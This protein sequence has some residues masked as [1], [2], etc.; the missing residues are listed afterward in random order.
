MSPVLPSLRIFYRD[1]IRLTADS[2]SWA[3]R[4]DCSA[5]D[6]LRL[7]QCFPFIIFATANIVRPAHDAVDYR[8]VV[9]ANVGDGW[10]TPDKTAVSVSA[11]QRH[12]MR[13]AQATLGKKVQRRAVE[14]RLV[15][16][17]MKQ[18]VMADSAGSAGRGK[19]ADEA[20]TCA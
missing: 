3:C 17:L 11:N 4:P 13:H 20:R 15:N 6:K 10:F 1:S 14:M 18:M 9:P 5:I 8:A 19:P 2:F 16:D 12:V 7:G